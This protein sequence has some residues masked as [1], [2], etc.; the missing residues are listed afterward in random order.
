M[1]VSR[2][3]VSAGLDSFAL[4]AGVMPQQENV[5]MGSRERLPMNPSSHQDWEPRSQAH[6]PQHVGTWSFR[7]EFPR[8]RESDQIGSTRTDMR[9]AQEEDGQ[10]SD[11][12]EDEGPAAA[13]DVEVIENDA[14]E[15]QQH[16]LPRVEVRRTVDVWPG[17]IARADVMTDCFDFYVRN[18]RHLPITAQI[19]LFPVTSGLSPSTRTRSTTSITTLR[20]CTREREHLYFH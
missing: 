9:L 17:S 10:K 5:A 15:K 12:A 3:R 18:R 20:K 19:G 7:G 11:R 6:P 14:N 8:Y 1:L 4:G 13:E 2:I 16:G